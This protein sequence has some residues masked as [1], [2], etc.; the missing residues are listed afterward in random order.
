M[1][2]SITDQQSY[3]TVKPVG[4]IDAHSSIEVD[5]KL[6]ELI[7]SGHKFFHLDVSELTYISSAGLGVIISQLDLL[8]EKQGKLIISGPNEGVM[9]VF[10]LLG[11]NQ[12]L[13]ILEN[14]ATVGTYFQSNESVS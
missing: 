7:A 10:E 8:N 6:Q 9:E 12:L 4:E 2:I 1:E 5:E 3:I 11:L 14:D 13:T